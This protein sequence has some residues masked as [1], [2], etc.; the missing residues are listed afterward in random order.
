ML[1]NAMITAIQMQA[2]DDSFLG[3][4][5]VEG[6]EDDTWTAGKGVLSQLKARWETLPKK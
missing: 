6:R 2:M 1:S 4:I 5:R 3:R